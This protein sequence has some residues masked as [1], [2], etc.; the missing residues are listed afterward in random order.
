MKKII[1]LIFGCVLMTG[2]LSSF[3]EDYSCHP[4]FQFVIDEKAYH[5][6]GK[7]IEPY[8]IHTCTLCGQRYVTQRFSNG[9]FT[10]QF[11]SGTDCQASSNGF[12]DNMD[13]KPIDPCGCNDLKRGVN[14][15]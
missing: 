6:Y 10:T 12:H 14:Y 11:V 9:E 1:F 2:G 8:Q 15:D 3:T 4:D 13:L 5:C 7:P